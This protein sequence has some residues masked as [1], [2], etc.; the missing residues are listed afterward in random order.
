MRSLKSPPAE[1]W[2]HAQWRHYRLALIALG[3]ADMIFG[4]SLDRFG[5]G[6]STT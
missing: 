6:L 5:N 1:S 4:G 2:V 3:N